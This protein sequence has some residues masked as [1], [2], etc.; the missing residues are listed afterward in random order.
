MAENADLPGEV[1]VRLSEW[2]V[3]RAGWPGAL[4]ATS[5]AE[6]WRFQGSRTSRLTFG[7]DPLP[8]LAGRE[9]RLTVSYPEGKDDPGQRLAVLAHFPGRYP[10]GNLAQNGDPRSGNLLPPR[11]RADAGVGPGPGARQPGPRPAILPGSLALPAILAGA[12]LALVLLLGAA[13]LRAQPTAPGQRGEKQ[14]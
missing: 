1:E 12:G 3:G 2:P 7:F 5:S 11:G 8:D 10:Y 9:Y 4:H 6:P 13:V 14:P